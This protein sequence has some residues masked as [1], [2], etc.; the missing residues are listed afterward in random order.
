MKNYIFFDLETNGLDLKKSAIMQI[1][2]INIS[3][4]II[5][6]KYIYPHDNIVRGTQIH[7]IDENTLKFNNAI[8]IKEMCTDI[9]KLLRYYYDRQDIYWIAYNN[10]G[11]DQI[12]LENN[13]G[14]A[15]VKIPNNWYFID[16]FPL[17]KEI[18]PD[19]K[20]NFKLSTV[21]KMI[22]EDE[23]KI[24]F[25]SSLDDTKCLY[26]IFKK[27]NNHEDKFS[28]YTRSLFKE[29]KIFNDP[30][31]S[32]HGYSSGMKLEN[33]DI[34]NI[35]DLYQIYKQCN[36]DNDITKE[37]FKNN[38]NIYSKFHSNNLVKQLENIK[39]IN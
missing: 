21:Y 4:S 1:T 22:V 19:I 17:V 34:H 25:H 26:E 33:K 39:Y 11:F 6:D 36:Y 7:G 14:I 28:K 12:I 2:I 32:L 9:K 31:T 30:L 37:Y 27:L 5:Y 35:G 16:L 3:G 20:P 10:F 29:N 38:L 15:G 23:S 18:Y 13:F 8:N 24:N